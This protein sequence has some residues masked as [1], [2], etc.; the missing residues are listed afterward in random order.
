MLCLAV[1][2]QSCP[3]CHGSKCIKTFKERKLLN[4]DRL[5][6]VISHTEEEVMSSNADPVKSMDS[7]D[8]LLGAQGR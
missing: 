8:F 3:F 6:L 1:V 5:V 7:S 4:T 2:S